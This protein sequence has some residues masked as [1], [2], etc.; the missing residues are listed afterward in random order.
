MMNIYINHLFYQIKAPLFIA[1]LCIDL[2]SLIIDV[3]NMSEFR[4]VLK[5]LQSLFTLNGGST[6]SL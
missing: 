1:H 4:K 2:C 3:V 6:I 5:Q